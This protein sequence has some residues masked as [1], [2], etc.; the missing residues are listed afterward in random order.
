MDMANKLTDSSDTIVAN[1]WIIHWI[2]LVI[3]VANTH[4]FDWFFIRATDEIEINLMDLKF[5]W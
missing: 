1:D 2:L 4:I 3:E 5:Q